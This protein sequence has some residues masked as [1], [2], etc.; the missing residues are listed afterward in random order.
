MDYRADLLKQRENILCNDG[1]RSYFEFLYSIVSSELEDAELTLEIGAGAAVSNLFLQN[2]ILRTDFLA[3]P[4]FGVEGDCPM[5]SLP[6]LDSSFEAV[7]AIDAIHH[8]THPLKALSE[9]LR[10]IKKGGKIVI[11]EPYV[12]LLSYLPYKLLH[13]EDTSWSFKGDSLHEMALRVQN[14]AIGN[15]GVSKFLIGN[16]QN[17]KE[18]LLT[19]IKFRVYYFS[20]ISFFATGGVSRAFRT[21]TRV[22]RTLTYLEAKIPQSAMKFLASRVLMVL[23][24]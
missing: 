3:F 8:S 1:L 19:N 17:D 20:P 4:K 9:F 14:P 24:K 10:L 16:L 6:F 2:R 21:P 12:S 18:N 11:V 22:I 7:I 13:H 15:Q 5:E 23:E